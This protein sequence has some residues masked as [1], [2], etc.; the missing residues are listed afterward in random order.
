MGSMP[1]LKDSCGFCVLNRSYGWSGCW[2]GGQKQGDGEE[3]AMVQGRG[4][5]APSEVGSGEPVARG[6]MLDVSLRKAN[7]ISQWIRCRVERER[8]QDGF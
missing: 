6:Q 2:K 5:V 7:R 3:A 8:V 4:L 1:P